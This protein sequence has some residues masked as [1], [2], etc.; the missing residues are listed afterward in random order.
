MKKD[1]KLYNIIFPLWAFYLFPF[2]WH[3]ILPANF[4]IDSIVFAAAMAVLK[5]ADK[6]NNYKRCI[7]RIWAYGFLADII[8]AGFLFLLLMFGY[9]E[10]ST[11][12]DPLGSPIAFA[13]TSLG[14][15]LAGVCIYLFNYKK[16]L[17][18][19]DLGNADRKRIAILIAVFTAPYAM[20]IST[21][22]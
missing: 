15:V 13:V 7:L 19:I 22:F 14:V 3:I 18:L 4:I 17:L 21:P 2:Y 11:A 6:K 8:G 5:I 20:Y 9:I 10:Y 12:F 16:V 1:I